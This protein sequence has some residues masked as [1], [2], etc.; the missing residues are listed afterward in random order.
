[1]K[2]VDIL[3]EKK[4]VGLNKKD[5]FEI[6]AGLLLVATI[7]TIPLNGLNI[8]QLLTLSISLAVSGLTLILNGLF[9]TEIV[10]LL[11]RTLLVI[12]LWITALIFIVTGFPGVIP[13]A[14]AVGILIVAR[15]IS[16]GIKHTREENLLLKR[17]I[18]R[19]KLENP[20][21]V[22]VVL[23]DVSKSMN[24]TD[25]LE[26]LGRLVGKNKVR[27]NLKI[28]DVRAN[29]PLLENCRACVNLIKKVDFEEDH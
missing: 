20:V 8:L 12:S 6:L 2:S 24:I 5:V 7:F 9:R 28:L 23:H 25:G 16:E 15:Y 22:L 21:P 18:A 14:F 17:I 27:I 26:V 4:K 19:G 1:M 29:K 10:S 11:G 3:V 13:I